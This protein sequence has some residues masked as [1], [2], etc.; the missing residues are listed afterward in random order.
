MPE[1]PGRRP[2]Q[3]RIPPGHQT[4]DD[5]VREL[6][7]EIADHAEGL[8]P[9]ADV[10]RQRADALFGPAGYQR[11]PPSGHALDDGVPKVAWNVRG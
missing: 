1:V 4:G 11:P 8:V 3:F 10:S 5:T 6:P 7:R 2:A 9:F